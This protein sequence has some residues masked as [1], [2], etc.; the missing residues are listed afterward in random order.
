M[1]ASPDD[2][3]GLLRAVIARPDL[4]SAAREYSLTALMKLS[5]RLPGVVPAV[6]V[7]TAH[8]NELRM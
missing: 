1:S 8:V 5:A 7:G 4:P 3:V 6:Q 2:V